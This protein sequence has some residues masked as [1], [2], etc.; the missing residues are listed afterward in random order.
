MSL[1]ASSRLFSENSFFSDLSRRQLD[2]Y[3][4][5]FDF[6]VAKFTIKNTNPIAAI[7]IKAGIQSK[8]SKKVKYRRR[9]RSLYYS[10]SISI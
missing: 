8:K 4:F 10:S 1:Y 3:L 6:L 5:G 9:K 7:A 2:I